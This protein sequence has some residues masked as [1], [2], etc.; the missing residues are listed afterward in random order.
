[1]AS[2]A[3]LG[4]GRRVVIGED[5]AGVVA[6]QCFDSHGDQGREQQVVADHREASGQREHSRDDRAEDQR[7]DPPAQDPA[8]DDRHA[9]GYQSDD[10]CDQSDDL[11]GAEPGDIVRDAAVGDQI[12][13]DVGSRIPSPM[14][15]MTS[16]R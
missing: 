4:G 6:A 8:A 15:S 5:V 11:E 16:A 13:L 3:L 1:M 14:F 9:Q 12:R 7:P 2:A 10:G